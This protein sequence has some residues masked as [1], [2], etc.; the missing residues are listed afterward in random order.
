M[1]IIFKEARVEKKKEGN[2]AEMALH[3]AIVPVALDICRME[4]VTFQI[5]TSRGGNDDARMKSL[6]AGE[7]LLK[8]G[9]K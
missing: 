3:I 6:N 4:F 9:I 5:H 1:E 7:K 8:K 2:D